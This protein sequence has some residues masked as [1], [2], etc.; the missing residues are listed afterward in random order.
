MKQ[1]ILITQCP[2]LHSMRKQKEK[3]IKSRKTCKEIFLLI[4]NC[5]FSVVARSL[6]QVQRGGKLLFEQN[7]RRFDVYFPIWKRFTYFFSLVVGDCLKVKSLVYDLNLFAQHWVA[8]T[9]LYLKGVV[10]VDRYMNL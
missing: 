10:I 5:F 4:R 3:E 2:H 9:Y 7:V 8:L 6:R 1:N